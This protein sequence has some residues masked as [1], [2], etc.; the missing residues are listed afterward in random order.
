MKNMSNQ[1]NIDI[2]IAS[3]LEKLTQVQRVLLWDIA[4]K[5]NLSPIQIQF[6]IFLNKHS[7]DLRKVSVLAEEFDLTKAT[8]SE[9]V[10]NLV[11]KGLLIKVRMKEDKRSYIL[12]FTRDG[13]KLVKKIMSW[14]D[15]L[16]SH[17]GKIPIKE[18]EN[19]NLVLIELIR[20]LFNDGVIT[21][22]RMCLTCEN[23]RKCSSGKSYRCSLTG[24]SFTDN[25]INIGCDFY[26]S[27][28]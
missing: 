23:I 13:I 11:D 10:S 16:V 8:V 27:I 4:K 14:Q 28:R 7:D 1:Y 12:D 22:A 9:A 25:E 2:N 24:R 19:V 18:K 5:E 17:L 15:V 21:I 3:C 20:S 26:K 6:L